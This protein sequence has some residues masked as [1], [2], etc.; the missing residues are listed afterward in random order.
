MLNGL[1][2]NVQKGMF[3]VK[4][5][6]GEL[7]CR[8]RGKLFNQQ[9]K[10]ASIIVVGDFVQVEHLHGDQGI[11]QEIG[12]RKSKLSRKIAGKQRLEQLVAANVDQAFLVCAVKNPRYSLNGID[13][14]I[15]AA[16]NGGIEPII[17]FNKVDLIDPEEIRNDVEHYQKLGI[18]VVCTSTLTG[19][20]IEEMR[21]ML[22]GKISLFTGSSGVGKSS[23][24]NALEG[25][26]EVKTSSVGL[27]TNKGRH[28]T[29]SAQI[30][31]IAS[32]GMI[33]DTPGMREFGLYEAEEGV[34]ELFQDIEE[35]ADRC[36]FK[37]CT[38][39]HEPGCAVKAALEN[40][41]LEEQRY[42]SYQKLIN[43]C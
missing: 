25:T 26:E 28:T 8:L 1:V 30:Y 31:E 35:L 2:M 10:T 43:E 24:V 6:K 13:R 23:L 4:T 3:I 34:R 18:Q 7:K 41:D 32:G 36:K 33:V 17:C 38:H 40:G 27:T 22:K 19:E 20:G 29:T 16:K 37:D 5:E 11:I 15:A 14:Y 39:R 12:E 9:Q 42:V 21:D